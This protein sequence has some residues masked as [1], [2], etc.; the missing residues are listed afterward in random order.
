MIKDPTSLHAI[1]LNS[2]LQSKDNAL[3][4]VIHEL[5]NGLSSVSSSSSS[6]SG[7]SSGGIP[8][9]QGLQGIQGLQGAPGMDSEN[10]SDSIII[11][12]TLQNLVSLFNQGLVIFAGPSGNLAQNPKFTWDDANG[13]LKI[14]K[15]FTDAS[16][17]ERL[18]VGGSGTILEIASEAAGTGVIRRIRI[19]NATGGFW[20]ILGAADTGTSGDLRPSS[21]A[22]QSIGQAGSAVKAIFLTSTLTWDG[23]AR[24]YSTVDAKLVLQN[25]ALAVGVGLDFT[26]NGILKFKLF[27]FSL[28]ADTVHARIGGGGVAPTYTLDITDAAAPGRIGTAFIGTWPVAPTYA[29]FGN[30]ALNQTIVGNYALLQDPTGVTFLNSTSTIHF[31][32]ANA[33]G[34]SFN[35]GAWTFGF[36]LLVTGYVSHTQAEVDK[37]YQIYTPATLATVT[38]SAGQQRAIINPAGT[39]AVL[40]VTLPPTPVDGQIAGISFTQ[41]VSAL[42]V[43]APG[44][45]TVVAAPTSAAV[46]TTFRFLYQ[47]SST[48]WFPAA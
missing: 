47:A 2:G 20:D 44:G 38:M 33:E 30:Q 1:L 42:T 14:Y 35:G 11:P 46:D 9:P 12:A 40:T 26:T 18:T 13:L 37:S 8:G 15:T 29:L 32:I 21:T 23:F 5:I 45:A 41:I 31:R 6:N 16:N 27:D 4:Q 3:Y 28:F 25:N 36:P 34:G 22:S 48:S 39:I 43:N 17:Y 7:G 24:I 10:Y 19:G